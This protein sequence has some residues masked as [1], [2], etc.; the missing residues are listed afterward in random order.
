LQAQLAPQPH[1]SP[2]LQG[3]QEQF[4]LEHLSVILLLLCRLG[5]ETVED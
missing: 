4:L 1:F 5:F 2:Q 3:W